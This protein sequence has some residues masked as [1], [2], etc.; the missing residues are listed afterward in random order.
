M[1]F[2]PF[3]RTVRK[4]I[5]GIIILLPAFLYLAGFFLIILFTVTQMAFT[6]AGT[7]K[8]FFPAL[9]NFV[10]LAQSPEFRTALLRTIIFTVAGTPLELLIGMAAAFLVVKK[11]KGRGVIRSIFILPLAIPAIV[12][13]IILYIL[14]DFPGG[15]I[16]E[17]IMGRHAFFP[18]QFVEYPVDWR[19]S[20]FSALAVSLAGKLW[21]DMP[22]SMLI[23]L[24]GLQSIEKDQTEAAATLGASSF[25]IFFKITIPLLSPAIAT[26]LVLRSIELWKEFIF[27][28]ILAGSYPL[29]STLIERA[30]HEWRSP[31]EASAIAVVLLVLIITCTM[32]IYY[33]LA[34]LKKRLVRI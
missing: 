28:Y 31:N 25:H 14:F 32:C 10:K 3:I 4:N 23:I 9:Q 18:C 8:I 7:E 21:R 30:Y 1:P 15:H 16:N 13:A 19:G 24:A 20:A 12:T 26:V 5:Y 29:L 11:F 27:P 6:Y 33:M 2:L 22:I 34:Y 17:I